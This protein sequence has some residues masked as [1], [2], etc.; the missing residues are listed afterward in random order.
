MS[1]SSL[2]DDVAVLRTQR[3]LFAHQSVGNNILQGV[4]ELTASA[5]LSPLNL[6]ELADVDLGAG[7]FVCDVRAGKNGAPETKV[8]A[9]AEIVKGPAGQAID[10]ALMKFCYVDIDKDTDV[11]AVFASYWNTVKELRASHPDIVFVHVTVPLRSRAP[12][13]KRV[14]KTVVGY[15]NAADIDAMKRTEFN[16]LLLNAAGS[17]PVFDLACVESTYDDGTRCSFE[18]EGKTVYTLIGEYTDDGGHLNEL[19]RRVVAREFIRTLASVRDS[20]HR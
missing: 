19:G 16:T 4:R 9:F 17:E 10:I 3:I 11:D 6:V 20:Q 8:N 15:G 5:G 7:N 18:R 1:V 14:I 13:W 12:G 2:S